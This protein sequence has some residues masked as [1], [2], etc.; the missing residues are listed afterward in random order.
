[1]D[2]GKRRKVRSGRGE[3]YEIRTRNQMTKEERAGEQKTDKDW[4]SDVLSREAL[5]ML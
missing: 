4:L 5:C 1:M 2:K 3:G